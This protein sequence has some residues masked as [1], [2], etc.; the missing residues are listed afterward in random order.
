MPIKTVTHISQPSV[1]YLFK[2][3]LSIA[4]SMS[5]YSDRQKG[6]FAICCLFSTLAIITVALWFWAR[7]IK[8]VALVLS[9]YVVVLAAV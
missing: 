5:S 4:D 2:L 3:H 7:K 1:E 8:G 6:L 9:D